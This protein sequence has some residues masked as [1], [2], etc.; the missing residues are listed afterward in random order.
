MAAYG[1]DLEVPKFHSAVHSP[2]FLARLGMLESCLLHERM[3][4]C[5]DN[6]TNDFWNSALAFGSGAQRELT[7]HAL[8]SAQGPTWFG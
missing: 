2:D 7:C 5:V 3:R 8:E 1:A 4:R 6:F